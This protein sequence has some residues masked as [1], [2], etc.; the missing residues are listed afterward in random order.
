MTTIQD[1]NKRGFFRGVPRGIK[2]LNALLMAIPFAFY[3]Y[4]YCAS[5]IV[6]PYYTKGN[7]GIFMLLFALIHIACSNRMERTANDK[8]RQRYLKVKKCSEFVSWSG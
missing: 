2:F 5:R 8:G 3:W 7:W 6:S 1:N 4:G